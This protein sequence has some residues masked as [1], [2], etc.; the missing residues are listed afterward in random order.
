MPQ[1]GGQWSEI[2]YSLTIGFAQQLHQCKLQ[3]AS[4]DKFILQSLNWP[5][6]TG[7]ACEHA[8]CSSGDGGDGRVIS[9]LVSRK[10]GAD[11]SHSTDWHFHWRCNCIPVLSCCCCNCDD[12]L[13]C[14]M[15]HRL[16]RDWR[17]CCFCFSLL[18]CR[19]F[20]VFFIWQFGE[21]GAN[22][23]LEPGK[24]KHQMLL[25]IIADDW[26]TSSARWWLECPPNAGGG[27]QGKEH[28]SWWAAATTSSHSHQFV[29]FEKNSITRTNL[30]LVYS[31][32]LF[33]S[34]T[35]Y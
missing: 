12:S 4:L 14:S 9:G 26:M 17:G 1:R 11:K 34:C 18:F 24:L 8:H 33:V 25:P 20:S 10:K 3:W 2:Y 22:W 23:L 35:V 19:H 15:W 27:I 30:V 5:H 29:V 21:E 16:I 32:I 6:K 31:C 28:D 13:H 7:L